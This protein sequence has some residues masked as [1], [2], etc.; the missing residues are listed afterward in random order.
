MSS[1]G[2]PYAEILH[3]ASFQATPPIRATTGYLRV[4]RDNDPCDRNGEG[5]TVLGNGHVDRAVTFDAATFTVLG[6]LASNDNDIV[7]TTLGTN[8]VTA[9]DIAL[10]DSEDRLMFVNPLAGDIEVLIGTAYRIPTGQLDFALT[11]GWDAVYGNAV[12]AYLLTNAAEPVWPE[13][14]IEYELTSDTP[15]AS[16]EGTTLTGDGYVN[17]ILD[18]TVGNYTITDNACA[19]AEISFGAAAA[20]TDPVEGHNIRNG[21][22]GA[23][24]F[25]KAYA[26]PKTPNAGNEMKW[27]EG[28]S[29][30]RLD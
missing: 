22:T 12:L 19:A 20:N 28:N 4:Y 6:L 2:Y 15:T 21:D 5:G 7:G 18:P 8:T 10:F 23:R 24:M 27:S 14:A 13:D 25:F 11:G 30:V 1:L 29:I 9:T 17:A 26:A 16:D 3:K